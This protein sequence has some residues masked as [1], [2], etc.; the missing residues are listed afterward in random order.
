MVTIRNHRR[1][2]LVVAVFGAI[3][4]AAVAV[5]PPALAADTIAVT[6]VGPVNVGVTYSCDDP[7]RVVAIDAMAGAPTADRP[8]ATGVQKD[9]T[10][11]GSPHDTVVVLTGLPLSAG[12]QVQI[13]VAL[14]DGN[15][16]VVSGQNALLTLG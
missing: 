7:A 16:T 10:C 15:E 5:A 14:V 1:P 12:Q 8:A 9:I 11:D 4:S 3:A 6:G 2:A 13:R